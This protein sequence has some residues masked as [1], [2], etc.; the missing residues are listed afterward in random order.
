MHNW[1]VFQNLHR[2]CN[3]FAL[4]NVVIL[5]FHDNN[6]SLIS[7]QS[8][9]HKFTNSW[10]IL[11][12]IATVLYLKVKRKAQPC[13]QPYQTKTKK[14]HKHKMT[15]IHLMETLGHSVPQ[16]P[17]FAYFSTQ[18]QF[19]ISKFISLLLLF[20]LKKGHFSHIK[21]ELFH[22]QHGYTVER[23][24][25]LPKTWGTSNLWKRSLYCIS[26]KIEMKAGGGGTCHLCPHP[27]H[28]SSKV[29]L[30]AI[31]DKGWIF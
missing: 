7:K 20:F 17:V 31:C 29:V 16:I 1:S 19:L 30:Q 12:S 18:R 24:F 15:L 3:K 2:L 14:T 23:Y 28:A 9:L 25:L 11:L 21:S 22:C 27:I 26:Q 5:H 13:I 8:N 10:G 6:E 4:P